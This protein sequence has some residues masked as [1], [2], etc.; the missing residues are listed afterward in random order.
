MK[1]T[2]TLEFKSDISNTF[3]KT[4]SAFANYGEGQ[5]IFG[6]DDDGN[7]IGL[8][9]TTNFCLNIKN[10]INDSISPKPQF[11]LNVNSTNNT[12]SLVVY[13]GL[14]KPYLYKGKAYKRNDT[15][16]IEVERGEL[17][18][19]TLE[20][21]DKNFE[22]LKSEDQNL[23]FNVLSQALQDTLK[24]DK[25]DTN[26]LKTMSFFSDK[27][28]YNNAAAL[29][30]DS[31]TFPGIDIAV[32]EDDDNIRYRNTIENVSV[33]TQ[34]KKTVEIFESNYL[35]ESIEGMNRVRHEKIPQRAF[36]EAIA[37]ALI[38]R[39]WDIKAHIKVVMYSD[40]IEISSPGGLTKGMSEDGY[41]NGLFSVL[42]NPILGG[43]FFRLR[44]IEH[45]ATGIKMIKKAY[46]DAL[47][48][49]AFKISSE[50]I[51]VELPIVNKQAL[52]TID[53]K[54]VMDVFV[55]GIVFSSKQLAQMSGFTKSKT[56]RILNSLIEKRR[57]VKT[58]G[59]RSV[60]YSLPY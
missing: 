46:I 53:E 17:T 23:T 40:R 36:R 7:P 58:G 34:L 55:K 21:C 18:R 32:M 28:G 5:I 43:V 57:I 20:G 48:K 8:T 45:F 30:A 9:D 3:L 33:I 24:I 56:I 2:K 49:P 6:V 59:G 31:N 39:T 13:E 4:V 1:E 51:K 10:K 25:V 19:L 35:Y 22:D 16:S 41:L 50:G 37:N 60:Y 29:V 47:Q 26:I 54:K 38:H 44:Y 11:S 52:I 15:S 42:R 27:D 14:D 12:V